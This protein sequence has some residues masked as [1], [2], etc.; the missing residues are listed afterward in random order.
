MCELMTNMAD[1]GQWP[2]GS[3]VTVKLR[4]GASAEGSSVMETGCSMGSPFKNG[5][6]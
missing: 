2:A 1:P 4:G 6:N 5:A 3:K